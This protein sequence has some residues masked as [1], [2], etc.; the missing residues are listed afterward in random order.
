MK[1]I[2][3]A[4]AVLLSVQ[5]A[6]A[7]TKTPE[8]AKKAVESAEAAAANP[9]KAAKLATWTKLASA[10]MDAYSAPAGA[11]WLGASK[12]ELQILMGNQKPI[13]TENVV[14]AGDQLVKEVYA[15]KEFYYNVNGQLA[16]INVTKPV[17]EDVLA[18]AAEAYRKAGELDTKGSKS[19]DIMAGLSNVASKYI[20]DGMNCYQFGDLA[21][22]SQLFEKAA[23]VSAIAPLSKVDTTALYNAAYTAWAGKDYERA[24]NFFEKCLAANYYYDGGEVF[25]KLGD[26][27]TNLGDAKKGA[28]TL[29]QG[30]VKFPQSQSILI[31]LINYYMTSGEN[32]DRLF[33]LIDEAKKNEPNNASLYYVEGNIYKEL[34][35]VEKAVES[36]YKCAEIN[37]EYEFGYIGAGILYY[38]LAI[39]LQEKAG[40]ELDDKKYNELVGQLEQALKDALDPFEKAYAVSKDDQLKV[41][42]AEYLKNIYYRFYS[43]G[44]EYEAGYKKYDEVV[45][46]G[47]AK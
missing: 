6:D 37:P 34:K 2:L 3:I 14:V 36:Y 47:V 13:S 22:A 42:V 43:N 28:E 21:K 27:Y 33:S 1:R 15:D 26:V 40:N 23:N 11:A 45:K 29:E 9:K 10:Y 39:E 30:F 31:G 12:Q 25:A 7:Q 17:V 20:D 4:L 19:K 8:A 24:K 38:E 16:I 44:P 18:K 35:N 46:S 5:V 32:T 41:S